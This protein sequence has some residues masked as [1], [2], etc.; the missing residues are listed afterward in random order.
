MCLVFNACFNLV[1][2]CQMG[3][4]NAARCSSGH[5]SMYTCVRCI[6]CVYTTEVADAYWQFRRHTAQRSYANSSLP[7]CRD[8]L[9]AVRCIGT[10][11][12]AKAAFTNRDGVHIDVNTEAAKGLQAL[13]LCLKKHFFYKV[14]VLSDSESTRIA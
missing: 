14:S 1:S 6:N 5:P 9:R 7:A 8:L 12:T 3:F 10:Y 2:F 11:V 13:L 4:I